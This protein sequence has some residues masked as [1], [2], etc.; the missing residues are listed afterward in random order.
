[1]AVNL[2]LGIACAV[3]GLLYAFS[4]ATNASATTGGETVNGSVQ[5][6]VGV[7]DHEKGL[8][9]GLLDART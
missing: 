7:L 3:S 8:K 1:M 9:T 2:G 4:G 5:N 6:G